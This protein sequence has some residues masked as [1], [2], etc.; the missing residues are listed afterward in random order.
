MHVG[1]EPLYRQS[2]INNQLSAF[3]WYA[4]WAHNI[5]CT[6][7]IIILIYNAIDCVNIIESVVCS[8]LHLPFLLYAFVRV[9]LVKVK[10]ML[11]LLNNGWL[12]KYGVCSRF[13]TTNVCDC[14]AANL[15]IRKYK[16]RICEI[17]KLTENLAKKR[18]KPMMTSASMNKN[19]L[20]K[21]EWNIMENLPFST[22]WLK[23]R[24]ARIDIELSSSNKQENYIILIYKIKHLGR[25][26]QKLRQ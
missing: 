13:L 8:V 4:G 16:I 23:S 26:A 10:H 5:T 14:E 17:E 11:W 20:Q 24:S 18:E 1:W 9:L 19:L 22:S 7:F 15:S 21:E 3:K 12:G 2:I 25:K 6:L